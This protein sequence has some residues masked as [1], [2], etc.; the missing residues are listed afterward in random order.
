M[1]LRFGDL[2]TFDK[3]KFIQDADGDYYYQKLNEK[4]TQPI[5]VVITP[6]ALRILQKY[7]F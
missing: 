7:N 4:T 1:S 6:T 5:Q 2:Q 3:G